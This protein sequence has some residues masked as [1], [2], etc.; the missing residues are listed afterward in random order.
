MFE[1]FIRKPILK[2]SEKVK[3]G[4]AGEGGYKKNNR[5]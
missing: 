1:K 2:I 4:E 5:W 3:R